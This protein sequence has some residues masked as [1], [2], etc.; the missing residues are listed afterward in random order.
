MDLGFF[1]CFGKENKNFTVKEI[2]YIIILL[3]FYIK[4]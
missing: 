3:Y 4:I 1:Y 2:W